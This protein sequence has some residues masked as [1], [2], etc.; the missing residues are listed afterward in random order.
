VEG[1][2]TLNTGPSPMGLEPDWIKWGKQ[3]RQ[4]H[5]FPLASCLCEQLVTALSTVPFCHTS[6]DLFLKPE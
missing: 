6:L 3:A 4:H 5:S 2:V 1:R